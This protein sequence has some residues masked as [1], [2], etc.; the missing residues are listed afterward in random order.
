ME[1]NQIAVYVCMK[2]TIIM[3]MVNVVDTRK[4]V[5][6]KIPMSAAQ[7]LRICHAWQRD[8]A[9]VDKVKLLEIGR[10]VG[11]AQWAN[12]ITM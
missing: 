8:S 2:M 7:N 12:G 11:I 3:E 5:L 4:T 10:L 9:D 1:N 6:P